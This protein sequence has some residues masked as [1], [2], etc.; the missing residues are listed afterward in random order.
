MFDA[1]GEVGVDEHLISIPQQ[2]DK[3]GRTV[4][5][6]VSITVTRS[7][8][9]DDGKVYLFGYFNGDDPFVAADAQEFLIEGKFDVNRDGVISDKDD[10]GDDFT[11]NATP[12]TAQ[13]IDGEF[14]VAGAQ[15]VNG[16]TPDE[17][18][19]KADDADGVSDGYVIVDG[20]M[21]MISAVSGAPP[22]SLGDNTAT[23]PSAMMLINGKATS[24][25]VALSMAT[26][27]MVPWPEPSTVMLT[28][29][30]SRS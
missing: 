26:T 9:G 25:A 14:N 8:A 6:A 15:A 2:A 28:S 11:N 19:D 4:R 30:P 24:T 21:Y 12:A 1:A 5:G 13:I 22:V 20:V 10:R 16:V 23:T 17:A 27:G 18:V 7:M 3:F 29:L